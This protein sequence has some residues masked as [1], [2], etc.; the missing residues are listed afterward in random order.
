MRLVF[1]LVLLLNECLVNANNTIY[2]PKIFILIDWSPRNT[3]Q[4]TL[5]SCQISKSRPVYCVRSFPCVGSSSPCC[6]NHFN[7]K[8]R[9]WK[10][11][12]DTCPC[13]FILTKNPTLIFISV[14]HNKYWLFDDFKVKQHSRPLLCFHPL[15]YILGLNAHL[16]KI[17][18][19]L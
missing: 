13:L 1:D 8:F 19:N 7:N 5:C 12:Y 14:S 9:H 6:F 15:K 16:F 3:Q 18:N 11:S 2:N 17:P 10:Q 4:F